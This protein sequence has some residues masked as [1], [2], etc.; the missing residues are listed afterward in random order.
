MHR[1]L[2]QVHRVIDGKAVIDDSSRTGNVHADG[3]ARVSLVQHQQLGHNG[4]GEVG[5]NRTVQAN[6]AVFEEA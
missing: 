3:G 1:A 2:H 5:A 6:N 4:E